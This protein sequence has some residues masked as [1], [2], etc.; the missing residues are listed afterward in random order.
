M[1]VCDSHRP[2]RRSARRAFTLI[3][4]LLVL[5]I[6]AILATTVALKVVGRREQAQRTAAKQDLNTI[7]TALTAFEID[8]G[9]FPTTEEG[10]A[11]LV[12][13][14]G[15]LPEWKAVLDKIPVDPWGHPYVYRCPGNG[16]DYDLLSCGP[17]G[18][19]GTADNILP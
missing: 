3:E 8:N 5:V 1:P 12:Q 10:L 14:P 18:Q 2:F 4:L 7:N 16:K 15:N 19:E 6:L 11:A 17:S 13:N 9:R